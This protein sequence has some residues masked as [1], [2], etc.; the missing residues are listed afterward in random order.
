M[1]SIWF[2]LLAA[3]SARCKTLWALAYFHYSSVVIII[4]IIS[5][6]LCSALASWHSES[7][8]LAAGQRQ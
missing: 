6:L 1:A 5:S 2:N 7:F 8:N 3:R 4:I